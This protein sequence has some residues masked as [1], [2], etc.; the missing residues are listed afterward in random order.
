MKLSPA[1]R[2]RIKGYEGYKRAL[3][4]GRC[5]AY[6]DTYHGKLDKP[7]I[8]W[9]CTEGVTMGMV[10]TVDE[11][12]AALSR[13]LAQFEAAVTRLVTVE[14]NQNE[15]DALVALSYNIGAGALG[16]STVLRRLNAGDRLGAAEAFN[17]FNRAGG[18]VVAGLVS[19]RNS[20]A[21]LFLRPPTGTP[22]SMP[23]TVEASAVPPKRSTVAAA[24]AT[25]ATA[26]TSVAASLPAPPADLMKQVAA[27]QPFTEQLTGFA[28]FMV[29]GP[30]PIAVMLATLVLMLVVPKIKNSGG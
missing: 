27:W 30:A 9:G 22:V 21:G 19:R 8:G 10:W 18:G 2:D 13:E 24:A 7:T 11:A 3:A 12:E 26:A 29:S 5:T 6:Q 16:S 1:G 25:A 14:I 23:Q 4:D 20:E 28:K 17:L 15:F